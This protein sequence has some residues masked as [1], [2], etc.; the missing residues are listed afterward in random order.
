MKNSKLLRELL[1]VSETFSDSVIKKPWSPINNRSWRVLDPSFDKRI[2]VER[3][4]TVLSYNI[5]NQAYLWPQV[6][7]EYVPKEYQAWDFRLNLLKKTL[8]DQSIKSDIMCLQEVDLRTF[9]QVWKPTFEGLG[10]HCE[11]KQKSKPIYW[12]KHIEDK[13][14]LDDE[15]IDGLTIIF[16]SKKFELIEKN[17]FNLTDH[18]LEMKKVSESPLCNIDLQY[19]VL[20]NDLKDRNQIAQIL[21]LKHKETKRII[22]LSNTHLYWRSKQIQFIQALVLIDVLR[23][24]KEKYP[25]KSTT[26]LTGDLNST[27]SSSVFKFLKEREVD[28]ISFGDYSLPNKLNLK[29]KNPIKSNMSIY[30]KLLNQ[31]DE[32]TE[33]HTCHTQKFQ[34]TLDYIWFNDKQL[35]LTKILTGFKESYFKSIPGLP[36]SD[37]P[38]DHLPVRAEFAIL[39]K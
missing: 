15:S 29:I 8:L 18:Y 36:N 16:N 37:Y 34:G 5:L 13:K 26:I 23:S 9:R 10:Y 24:F 12:D 33:L 17:E 28:D 4:F 14:D 19:D 22:I 27:P 2:P 38:S 30:E 1:K 21:V 32:I 3:K 6:Y 7:D 20:E 25:N 35:T 39:D 31:T 11:Y